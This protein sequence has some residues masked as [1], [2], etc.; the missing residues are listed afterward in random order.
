MGKNI[1]K[2]KN[3]FVGLSRTIKKLLSVKKKKSIDDVINRA[4]E[5]ISGGEK[6]LSYYSV[7]FPTQLLK[8]TVCQETEEL[9]HAV[10]QKNELYLDLLTGESVGR[11]RSE[12]WRSRF[13]KEIQCLKHE[14]GHV[15]LRRY[16]GLNLGPCP[17]K[18]GTQPLELYPFHEG[19]SEA[20]CSPMLVV[21]SL[22]LFAACSSLSASVVVSRCGVGWRSGGGLR[23]AE[24]LATVGSCELLTLDEAGGGREAVLPGGEGLFAYLLIGVC[25]TS[26]TRDTVPELD[27]YKDSKEPGEDTQ[28]KHYKTQ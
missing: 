20:E 17:W 11:R 1:F 25:C 27:P 12:E 21:C 5:E 24:G 16:Q 7:N 14:S 4:T 28:L 13:A 19:D 3:E 8:D 15:F 18:A 23:L 6:N 9:H 26:W 22:C 2:K 10:N